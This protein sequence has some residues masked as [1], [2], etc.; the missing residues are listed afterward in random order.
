V[1]WARC[2]VT[3]LKGTQMDNLLNL[4]HWRVLGA[5]QAMLDESGLGFRPRLLWK[6][7][8]EA[9][10]VQLHKC[11]THVTRPPLARKSPHVRA[12]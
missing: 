11:F 1:P 7:N 5:E 4:E 10:S 9:I 8:G 6:P 12:R 2:V 3:C